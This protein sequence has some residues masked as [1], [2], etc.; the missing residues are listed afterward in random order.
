MLFA[1]TD[2]ALKAMMGPIERIAQL[3]YWTVPGRGEEI[4]ATIDYMNA[5]MERLSGER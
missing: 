1:A 3:F 2:G 4:S 5:E